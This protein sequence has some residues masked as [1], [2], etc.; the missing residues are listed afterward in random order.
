MEKLVQIHR[1]NPFEGDSLLQTRPFMSDEKLYI[2]G[3]SEKEK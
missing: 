3:R 1:F 2:G